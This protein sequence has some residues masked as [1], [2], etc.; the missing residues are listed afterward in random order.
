MRNPELANDGWARVVLEY[1]AIDAIDGDLNHGQTLPWRDSTKQEI[2]DQFEDI[3]KCLRDRDST[4]VL[5]P[6]MLALEIGRRAYNKFGV[7][8]RKNYFINAI[9]GNVEGKEGD[10]IAKGYIGVK[11]LEEAL[12]TKLLIECPDPNC[13]CTI[14][15]NDL[16]VECPDPDCGCHFHV[17]VEASTDKNQSFSASALR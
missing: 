7:H 9:D 11:I 15:I 12:E 16:L 2:A 13:E 8:S 10:M 6:E 1:A 5:E 3:I 4:D 17:D 14:S